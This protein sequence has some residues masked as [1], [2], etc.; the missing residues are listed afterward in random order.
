MREPPASGRRRRASASRPVD[1]DVPYF[2]G[3]LPSADRPYP[4]RIF[5]Y[6]RLLFL[7]GRVQDGHYGDDRQAKFL[8]SEHHGVLYVER[9]GDSSFRRPM[10]V[11]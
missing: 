2:F 1:Y 4:F 7:R 3:A 11:N 10:E 9:E 6:A 5:Q 8:F